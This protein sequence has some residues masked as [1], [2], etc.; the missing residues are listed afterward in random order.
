MK[1]YRFSMSLVAVALSFSLTGCDILS[2]DAAEK[3]EQAASED[4]GID[5][6]TVK[7]SSA[8]NNEYGDAQ[9][10]GFENNKF[11]ISGTENSSDDPEDW[12]IFT[13]P[14]TGRYICGMKYE[15]GVELELNIFSQGHY[16]VGGSVGSMYSRAGTDLKDAGY[17]SANYALLA[18]SDKISNI[19]ED[20]KIY[21]QVKALS[22]GGNTAEYSL[23]CFAPSA[24]VSQQGE[25][26]EKNNFMNSYFITAHEV[27][28]DSNS[29]LSIKGIGNSTDDKYDTFKFTTLLGGDYNVT[30]KHDTTSDFDVKLYNKDETV[31]ENFPNGAKSTESWTFTALSNAVYFL[32]VEAYSTG[33][34]NA[35][36]TVSI[37][38]K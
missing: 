7:E 9:E 2:G 22:T 34:S 25:I 27:V 19:P 16:N 21:M 20:D 18:T 13:T 29:K 36:Y 31:K 10:V 33:G 4:S 15:D 35:D 14:E 26:V 37:V 6:G 3:A 12:Y 11:S 32:R 24:Y 1:I 28:L 23:E 38:K 8:S 30:L 17:K 5:S